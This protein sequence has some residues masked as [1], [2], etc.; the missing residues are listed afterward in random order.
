[1][2]G[3]TWDADKST[4]S[5]LKN[6][7]LETSRQTLM[8]AFLLFGMVVWACGPGDHAVFAQVTN[9]VPNGSFEQISSCPTEYRQ[10]ALAQPWFALEDNGV[11]FASCSSDPKLSPP[12]ATSLSRPEYAYQYPAEGLNHAGFSNWTTFPNQPIEYIGVKLDRELKAGEQVYVSAKIAPDVLTEQFVFN[13]QFTNAVGIGL[14]HD[15]V[16]L[17]QA[18]AAQRA[19]AVAQLRQPLVDTANWTLLADCFIAKG[20]ERYLILGDFLDESEVVIVNS[21]YEE[22]FGRNYIL[23]DDVRLEVYD[24][25]PDT[26]LVCLGQQTFFETGFSDFSISALPCSPSLLPL[27]ADTNFVQVVSATKGECRLSD[28]TLIIKAPPDLL[29]YDSTLTLCRGDSRSLRAPLPG[30]VVWNDGY[31][32]A[33]RV[34][35]EGG[36]YAGTISNDCG[37]FEFIYRV[38]E[39]DCSCD[40]VSPTAFS[41][42]DDGTNDVLDFFTDCPYVLSNFRLQVYDR[43]GD[44][45]LDIE[46]EEL[47]YWDGRVDGRALNVGNYVCLLHYAVNRPGSPLEKRLITTAVTL[48]K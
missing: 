30:A 42:N 5:P 43:W 47:P 44:Q 4:W 28:T 15:T 33:V 2:N 45:L 12:S 27:C 29:R 24:P 3:L 19:T 40:V 13:V 32:E 37:L 10:L 16:G 11:L 39:L 6:T 23:V 8:R 1:M 14:L 38:E 9:L 31:R 18:N 22:S 34:I 25:Y 21:R 46:S 48:L 41:P 20:G 26:V 36:S 7:S 35:E 17:T